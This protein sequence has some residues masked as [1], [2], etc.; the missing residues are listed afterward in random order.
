VQEREFYFV[1]VF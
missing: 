1:A